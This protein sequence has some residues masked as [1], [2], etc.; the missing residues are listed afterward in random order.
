MC[1][2]DSWLFITGRVI[3]LRAGEGPNLFETSEA[4]EIIPGVI[5]ALAAR[6][7]APYETYMTSTFIGL[8]Q[9]LI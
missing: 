3:N 7:I 6:F 5:T 9:G 4:S 2:F 1:C 8:E